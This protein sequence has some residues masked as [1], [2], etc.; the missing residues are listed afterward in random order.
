VRE[1]WRH[2]GATV[3]AA[4]VAGAALVGTASTVGAA[5][6]VAAVAA[7]A[8]GLVV[9]RRPA[10]GGLALVGVAP[11]VSGLARGVPLP[12]LRL[13]EALIC[14][15]AVLVLA[16]ADDR[17]TPRWRAFDW[18]ALLYVVANA[19]L[20]AYDL[21]ARDGAFDVDALGVVAGPLQFFLLYRAALVALRTEAQRRRAIEIALVLSVPI[22]VIAVLQQFDMGGVR[23]WTAGLVSDGAGASFTDD[24]TYGVLPRAVGLFPHWQILGGY[25]LAVILL[26]AASFMDERPAFP[27]P[28]LGAVLAIDAAALVE[29][30]TF[31]NIAAAVLGVLALAVWSRRGG[32]V[33]V[34]LAVAGVVAAFAFG[35]SLGTRY[36]LQ[37]E[38]SATGDKPAL[39]PQTL[40]F[41]YDVWTQQYFPALEDRLLTGYGPGVP[42][43]IAF[44]YTE[45]VYLELL[46]RGG[47]PLLLV[48]AGLMWALW[49]A[50]VPVARGP[51]ADSRRV[52]ARALVVL[53]VALVPLHLLEP[54]FITTGLPHLL[55]ALAALALGEADPR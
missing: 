17:A 12:G 38:A 14:G 50:A 41:R 39:V 47:V 10:A 24:Y 16:S 42:P 49:V 46:V 22:A 6:G 20:G 9:L 19:A 18:M 7:V 54:F 43:G 28:L 3:G 33:V 34:W 13:S 55:W 45:S 52:A 35:P 1:A 51:T 32:R 26:G 5:A 8:L 2:P 25:L 37:M 48:F 40:A 29:T 11:A 30:L 36:E 21:L 53:V 15:V 4:G 31:A 23:A 44:G 27:R